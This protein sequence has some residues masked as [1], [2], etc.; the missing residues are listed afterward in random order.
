[1]QIVYSIR[2]EAL[3]IEQ[4]DYNLLFRWFVGLGID[5]PVWD[6]ST[7]RKNRDGLIEA[8]VAQ[9]FWFFVILNG[10]QDRAR[11]AADQVNHG[12]EGLGVAVAAGSGP[13]GLEQAV[14]AFETGIGIG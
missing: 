3:L 12:H 4:L 1:M 10:F 9:G 8:E 6:P 2:S 11:R 13:S 7:F 14:E 5:D